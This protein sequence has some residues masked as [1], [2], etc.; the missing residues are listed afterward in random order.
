MWICT[1]SVVWQ[2]AHLM[3]VEATKLLSKY[4]PSGAELVTKKKLD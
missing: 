1:S 2:S 3:Q 4:Q